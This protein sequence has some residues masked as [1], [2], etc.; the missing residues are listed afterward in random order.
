MGYRRA[1]TLK[2]IFEDEEF[3]GLEVRV[4]QVPLATFIDI[5]DLSSRDFS[6]EN[7]RELF[8]EFGEL[9]ESWNVEDGN[10]QPVPA[11][12]EGLYGMD[13]AFGVRL[14]QVWIETVQGMAGRLPLGAGSPSGKPALEGSLPMET[15]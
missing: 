10:G 7:M 8:R 6:T 13:W 11:T 2:L 4:R 1:A 9:L 3:E 15:L 14:V 12:A 5:A